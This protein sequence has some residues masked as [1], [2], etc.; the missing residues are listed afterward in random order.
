M[1]KI[2]VLEAGM[3]LK[4]IDLKSIGNISDLSLTFNDHMNVICG[5]NGIGKTTILKSIQSLFAYSSSDIKKK[6]G[7][8]KGTIFAESVDGHTRIVD[9]VAVLPNEENKNSTAGDYFPTNIK[10]VIT[11]PDNRYI[12]YK[13]LES[14]SRYPNRTPAFAGDNRLL[15]NTVNNTLKDWLA[16]RIMARSG[17]EN[18]S[19]SERSNIEKMLET[20]SV[21]DPEIEY[22]SLN[23]RDLEILLSDHGNEVFFEFESTGF[24]NIMFIVLG[25]I[26]EIEFRFKNMKIE[27]F[28]GMILI[29]EV[30]LH[31][32]PTWQNKIIDILRKMFPNAQFIITT[33][34]PAVLQSLDNQ[35]IIPLYLH[36]GNVEIKTLNLSKYGLKGWTLEEIL[37]DV[38]GV[39]MLKNKV[40]Q[41]S[42][43]SF[44]NALDDNDVELAKTEYRKLNEMLHPESELRQ[45]LE[46]QKAG[47]F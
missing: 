36:N 32:H 31:L 7:T 17:D 3:K 34:S 21:I 20:F 47:L 15:K 19:D 23:Y 12:D 10:E 41:N 22:K 2:K 35:E 18:L 1:S 42:L 29:D 38:M 45:I 4:K 46:I 8:K 27:D 39:G 13:K 14:V 40:L 28:D 44:S 11:N 24:K 25:I 5:T 43:D 33:H 37:S 6:Y 16:N 26:E 9:I 30:E